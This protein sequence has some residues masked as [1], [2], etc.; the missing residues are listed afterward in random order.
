MALKIEAGKGYLRLR[1]VALHKPHLPRRDR[2]GLWRF[3]A[4]KGIDFSLGVKKRQER[5]F[6]SLLARLK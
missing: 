5:A 3:R 4:P 2:A 6:S 1:H